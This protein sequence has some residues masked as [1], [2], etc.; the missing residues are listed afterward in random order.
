MLGHV[1]ELAEA[2]RQLQKSIDDPKVDDS[3]V[4]VYISLD[5]GNKDKSFDIVVKCEEL[6]K[7]PEILRQIEVLAPRGAILKEPDQALI[8]A[9]NHAAT[10]I[11]KGVRSGTEP[12]PGELE[13]TIAIIDWPPKPAY[14]GGDAELMYY[15]NG[16]YIK[17]SIA[18][19]TKT[20]GNPRNVLRDAVSKL[21]LPKTYDKLPVEFIKRL[22][23]IDGNGQ[24]LFELTNE[25]PGVRPAQWTWKDLQ[26]GQ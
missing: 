18:D 13:A 4:K 6:G 22:N 11:P 1:I 21:H 24:M 2:Q 14:V 17:R 20:Y 16:D 7:E 25:T 8:N 26:G 19:P 3:S 10:K 15:S 5:L 23:V 9:I 12:P